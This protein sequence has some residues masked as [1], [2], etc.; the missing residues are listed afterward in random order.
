ME[1]VTILLIY[2][3]H[4][5]IAIVL[6]PKHDYVIDSGKSDVLILNIARAGLALSP[7]LLFIKKFNLNLSSEYA[8]YLYYSGLVLFFVSI[9]I[10]LAARFSLK[11]NFY[12]SAVIANHHVLISNGIYKWIRHPIYLS[13][14]LTWLSVTLIS[15]N[16]GY[17][18]FVSLFVLRMIIRIPVE[19]KLLVTKFGSQYIEY[20]K[21]AGCL[22]P[23]LNFK[24]S[25]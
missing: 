1:I 4:L 7:L 15:L 25:K 6:S 18:I 16:W 8:E 3:I 19:E 11:T 13:H 24:N 23:K 22:L 20:K 10:H 21:K 12:P 2:L 14:I 17:S 9:T 5:L